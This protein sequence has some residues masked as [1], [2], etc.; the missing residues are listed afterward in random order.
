[1]CQYFSAIALPNGDLLHHDS[2]DSHE[3]L[4]AHFGLN[5]NRLGR[6]ARI[7][8]HPES[9]KHLA[10]ITK[11]VLKLDENEK[12]KWWTNDFADKIESK[13][14]VI[15]AARIVIKDR[16]ILLGGP[17]IV[18][19]NAKI[20]KVY[21]ARILAVIDS[22]SIQNVWG[23]ASIQNVWGSASIQDVWGSA[24]IQN[25]LGSASIQNVG[26][27]ASIHNVGG[28]AILDNSAKSHIP[29]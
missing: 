5:D 9:V 29:K 11:Y 27:S 25:V 7:E 22:A 4:V 6:F 21:N 28:S 10:D 14:R 13:C 26:G 18:A 17:W 3:D 2:T 24:S 20:R 15:C 19:S 12:P 1:M 23:S 16:D 8:Y